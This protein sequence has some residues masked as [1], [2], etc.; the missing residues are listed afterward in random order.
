MFISNQAIDRYVVIDSIFL[1]IQY[2]F[3]NFFSVRR[4]KEYTRTRYYTF[5]EQ[6]FCRPTENVFFR[7]KLSQPTKQV[8]NLSNCFFSNKVLIF[9]L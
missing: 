3:V 2:S 7:R 8:A 1:L 9:F 6:K 4:F 5:G